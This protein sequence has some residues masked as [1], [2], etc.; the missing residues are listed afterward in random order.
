MAMAPDEDSDSPFP[1]KGPFTRLSPRALWDCQWEA[2]GSMAREMAP[3]I[4]DAHEKAALVGCGGIPVQR[5]MDICRIVGDHRPC[6]II[7][8]HIFLLPVSSTDAP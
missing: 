6:H 5:N 8:L 7:Q 4:R 3:V 1:Q 2:T